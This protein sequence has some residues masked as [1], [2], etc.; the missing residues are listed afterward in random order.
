MA[1]IEGIDKVEEVKI[2]E[3]P[4]DPEF[5]EERIMEWV[6]FYRRNIH[7][8]IEH[9]MGIRLYWFQKIMAYSLSVSEESVVL[10]ARGIGKTWF[11]AVLSCAICILYP[12]SKVVVASKTKKQASLIITR[13]IQKELMP[14]SEVLRKE[15]EKITT[16]N[17]NTECIFRNGSTII[18]VPATEN[19]LGERA[20]FEIFE[21]YK[22]QK[23]EIIES[24]LS[25]MQEVRK[26][27]YMLLPEYENEKD[28]MEE[29]KNVYI[30]SAWLNKTQLKL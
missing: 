5:M 6:T 21:E 26:P 16:T 4:V 18:V 2:K 29:P 30:S 22:L 17:G 20:T 9:Y 12:G 28:L 1:N 10:A 11:L 27:P 19:A 3:S 8:F 25:P 24:V 23:K 13:K 15:I 14:R 7:R